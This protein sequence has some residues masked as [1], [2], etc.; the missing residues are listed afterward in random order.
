MRVQVLTFHTADSKV[1]ASHAAYVPG[2]VAEFPG[3]V[4]QVA[5]ARED[6]DLVTV[7]AWEDSEACER[8]QHS[9]AYARL[10]L[11]PHLDSGDD[12]TFEARPRI[13]CPAG[14]VNDWFAAVA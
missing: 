3:L 13:V 4:S 1:A 8:F 14:V 9:E 10:M 7:L 12:H 2:A 5:F 6:G 11:D